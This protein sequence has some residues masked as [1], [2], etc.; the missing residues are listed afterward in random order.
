MFAFTKLIVLTKKQKKKNSQESSNQTKVIANVQRILHDGKTVLFK[1][2]QAILKMQ[3][4]FKL[5][6]TITGEFSN[7]L[8]AAPPTK[9]NI[10]TKRNNKFWRYSVANVLTEEI[11]YNPT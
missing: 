11:I 1:S 3:C 9:S 10:M 2:S 6:S 8:I 5:D 7:I 4:E